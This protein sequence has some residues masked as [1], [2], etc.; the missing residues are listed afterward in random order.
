MKW[1]PVFILAFVVVLVAAVTGCNRVPHYD[2]RLT[3]ADSLMQTRPDSALA[4]VEAVSP[5]SLSSEGDRAYHDLLLTQA[6]YRCYVVATSDSAINRALGY[7]SNH[8]NEREKLT[9]AYIYKGAVMEELGHP[10]SAMFYYKTAE[11]TADDDDYFNLGYANLRIGELYQTLGINDSAVLLRMKQAEQNFTVIG[12]TALLVTAIGTQ[13]LYLYDNNK[14]SA[15]YYL[16]KAIDLAREI[17][18]SKMF[19]YQ[20]KLAGLYYYKKNYAAAKDLSM[21]IIC[22]GRDDC[23]EYQFYYYAAMSFI[24]LSRPDSALWVK[25]MIPPPAT[26]IDRMNLYELDAALAEVRH[27]YNEY[28]RCMLCANDIN[29]SIL[30]SSIRNKNVMVDEFKIDSLRHEQQTTTSILHKSAFVIMV[31]IVIM[32]LVLLALRAHMRKLIISS[33]VAMEESC[34]ALEEKIESLNHQLSWADNQNRLLLTQ[35]DCQLAEA[36]KRNELL[37]SNPGIS[38]STAVTR[39]IAALDLLYHSIRVKANTPVNPSRHALPLRALIREMNERRELTYVTLPDSFWEKLSASIDEQYLGLASYVNKHYT[40]LS[41]RDWQLFLLLCSDVPH[42]VI[43]LCI[44]FD[45]VVTV[46]NYKRKLMK[47][48]TGDNI[49]LDEFIQHF[50]SENRVEP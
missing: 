20:S 32:V 29:D 9:R 24:R 44:H 50:M 23:D 15:Q 22:H 26:M 3:A 47:K 7:Y 31:I 28:R 19:F 37:Q 16:E 41:K 40:S 36:K 34:H 30:G 1:L 14:D 17:N 35:M 45:H 38:L 18:S 5:G 49:S 25:E 48:L 33:R 13:G 39:R 6:R 12:D 8:S 42:Q 27:D 43:K 46:S 4:L 21:Q 2:S 11:A 10:D